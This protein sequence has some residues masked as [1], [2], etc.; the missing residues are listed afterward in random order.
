[1][2]ARLNNVFLCLFVF[3]L[4]LNKLNLPAIED[5]LINPTQKYKKSRKIKKKLARNLE[6]SQEISK[7]LKKSRII[8]KNLEKSRIIFE[9]P[10]KS[11]E[12]PKH[13]EKFLKSIK[14]IE[15]PKV[16]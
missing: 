4:P 14:I 5:I 9:N 16:L 13:P 10:K 1:M 3:P 12:I 15:V 7:N 6:K 11:Q 2:Y 8:S